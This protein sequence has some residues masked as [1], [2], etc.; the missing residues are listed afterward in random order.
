MYHGIDRKLKSFS[1]PFVLVFQCPNGNRPNARFTRALRKPRR[2]NAKHW[3]FGVVPP[4]GTT[5]HCSSRL[6]GPKEFFPHVVFCAAFTITQI[7]QRVFPARAY[8]AGFEGVISNAEPSPS[9]Q[10]HSFP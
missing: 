5:I 8:Q 6:V 10:D 7:E 1:H 4:P 9:S 2:C 3:K